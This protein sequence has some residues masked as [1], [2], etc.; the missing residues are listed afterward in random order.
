M[1]RGNER[2]HRLVR[3]PPRKIRARFQ[4]HKHTSLIS[5]EPASI[6]GINGC[7]GGSWLAWRTASPRMTL[8]GTSHWRGL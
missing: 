4:E 1:G 8:P 7:Y 3:T 5:L 6:K 2:S